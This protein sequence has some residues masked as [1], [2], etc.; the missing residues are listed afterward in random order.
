[1][2]NKFKE[3][4]DQNPF[5]I[6][7]YFIMYLLGLIMLGVFL[8]LI[9]AIGFVFVFVIS[10]PETNPITTILNMY[11]NIVDSII[12]IEN[13]LQIK[14]PFLHISRIVNFIPIVLIFISTLGIIKNLI[15][16]NCILL[17]GLHLKSIILLNLEI[18]IICLT[19]YCISILIFEISFLLIIMIIYVLYKTLNKINIKYNKSLNGDNND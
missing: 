7:Q 16:K 12:Y 18:S 5:V 1:M 3:F 10:P 4:Y 13:L 17:K 19:P 15:T 6:T 8:V 9:Y 2:I 11:N 14:E